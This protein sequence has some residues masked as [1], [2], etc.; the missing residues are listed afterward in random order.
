VFVDP[1]AF[2]AQVQIQILM[3]EAFTKANGLQHACHENTSPC[4]ITQ[5]LGIENAHG[6]AQQNDADHGKV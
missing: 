4:E 1:P 2:D 3:T 5:P 6:E